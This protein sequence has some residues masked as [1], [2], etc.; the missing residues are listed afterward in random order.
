M[1][2][3]YIIYEVHFRGFCKI[4]LIRREHSAKTDVENHRP[5]KFRGFSGKFCKAGAKW[6]MGDMSHKGTSW[7]I[8]EECG[9]CEN[10]WAQKQFHYEANEAEASV[11]PL[12]ECLGPLQDL[13]RSP[14]A[15]SY[16]QGFL[17]LKYILFPSF[18]KRVPKIGYRRP[19]KLWT[20]L[21]GWIEA[22]ILWNI[23]NIQ[24]RKWHTPCAEKPWALLPEGHKCSCFSFPSPPQWDRPCGSDLLS[25]QSTY[26]L[27]QVIAWPL[28]TIHHHAQSSE[29]DC[30]R[31]VYTRTNELLLGGGNPEI[32]PHT[33]LSM[34]IHFYIS[35]TKGMRLNLWHHH[36]SK[37]Q[38][39]QRALQ[40][41]SFILHS[42]TVLLPCTRSCG[43]FQKPG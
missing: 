11:S 26:G 31:H 20:A 19:H 22:S 29:S 40:I 6:K 41:L 24:A 38:R 4:F 42:C 27:R 3:G 13:R 36:L 25:A 8:Q 34:R 28:W 18:L 1:W 17:N 30:P 12:N 33:N 9:I 7:M 15:C 37:A 5:G 32:S 14:T 16:D 39:Y 10:L 2:I 23:W 35:Y 21:P 43:R